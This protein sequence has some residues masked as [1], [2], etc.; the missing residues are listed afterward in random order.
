VNLA[1]IGAGVG[2]VFLGL[3][4]C[5]AGYASV[6]TWMLW[7]FRSR[8]PAAAAGQPSISVL[9]PM[10][11]DEP[12]LYENLASLCSQEYA[13]A[14]QIIV[15]VGDPADP[16]L[17]VAAQVKRDQPDRDIALVADPTAHGTNRKLSN[18][19]NMSVQAR[20]EVVIISDSDVRMPRDGFNLIV[21]AL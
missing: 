17:D 9:R 6:A 18:L 3:A 12:E 4:V 21:G 14:V 19:I 7:R 15:G 16:A 13:G 20:G 10:H 11:G 2:C 1:A 8:P 5:G